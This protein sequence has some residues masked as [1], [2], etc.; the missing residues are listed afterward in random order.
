MAVRKT[1]NG[2]IKTV[3][4]KMTVRKTLYCAVKNRKGENDGTKDALLYREKS[5]RRKWRYERR[6]MVP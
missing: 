2:A 5:Q 1:L 4:E 6:S 3:K